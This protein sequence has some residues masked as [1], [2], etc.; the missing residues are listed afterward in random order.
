MKELNEKLMEAEAKNRELALE[1]NEKKKKNEILSADTREKMERLRE[2][3][4]MFGRSSAKAEIPDVDTAWIK[5]RCKDE[6][7]NQLDFITFLNLTE[8]R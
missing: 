8:G 2:Q 7:V 4:I 1:L 6:G 5:Q 3:H